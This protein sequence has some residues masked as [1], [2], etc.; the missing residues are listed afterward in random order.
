MLHTCQAA[1]NNGVAGLPSSCILPGARPAGA[2]GWS[3]LLT[4]VY[5]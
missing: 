5:F 1:S 3:P 4:D 2:R